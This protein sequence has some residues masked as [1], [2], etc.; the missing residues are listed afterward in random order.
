MKPIKTHKIKTTKILYFTDIHFGIRSDSLARLEVC[1]RIIDQIVDRVKRDKIEHVIFGGDLFHSRVSLNVNTLSA[2]IESI[3]LIAKEAHVWMIIGN[4]DIHYKNNTDVHSIE[5][6]RDQKN[7]TVI[8]HEPLMLNVN[9]EKDM[10]LVPWMADLS[11]L[12]EESVDYMVGHFDISHKY[13]IASYVEEHSSKDGVSPNKNEV[14]N[15]MINN[16]L[17]SDV[18]TN[19]SGEDIDEVVALKSKSIAKKYLGN[20]VNIC[21]KSGTILAGHIH[22]HKSFRVKG[23]KFIFIGSPQ[24]QNFGDRDCEKN[25]FYV[26]D[27]IKDRFTFV[28]TEGL[29]VH[30]ELKLSEIHE[31]GIDKFD[32]SICTNNYVKLIIDDQIDHV[33]YG[34]V[35]QAISAAEPAEQSPPEYQVMIAFNSNINEDDL[36]KNAEKLKQSKPDYI[37]DYIESID[38]DELK[39]NDI[40][41]TELFEVV[42]RYYKVVEGNE[43]QEIMK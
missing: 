42:M 8:D 6:F 13:L 29:P 34:N 11:G 20:F 18:V 32:Y 41:K 5:L 25:G 26:H 15:E 22:A 27:V 31:V 7:I 1:R 17:I 16:E 38:E 39:P 4:H 30:H 37:F 21:K 10:L 23:R 14:L 43:E 28:K 3:K 24:Q 2:A 36:D 33:T 9:G 19:S 35:L 40:D 12:K